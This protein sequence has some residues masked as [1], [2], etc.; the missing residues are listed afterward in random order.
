MI[1]KNEEGLTKK[2]ERILNKFKDNFYLSVCDGGFVL[3]PNGYMAVGIL[4]ENT[5]HGDD[6]K[7]NSF[8]VESVGSST[9]FKSIKKFFSMHY[10]LEE[11][12]ALNKCL[13]YAI[14]QYKKYNGK[15]YY[16]RLKNLS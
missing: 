7:I 11:V 12:K 1:K 8:L 4:N 14:K 3:W 2:Q 13:S 10:T 6:K 16:R 9:Y 15:R 5:D